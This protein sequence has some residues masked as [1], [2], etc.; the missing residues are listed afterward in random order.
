MGRERRRCRREGIYGYLGLIHP[1]GPQK[2]TASQGNA[3]QFRRSV[4]AD[5]LRPHGPQYARPPCPSP[6]PRVHPDLCPW[7][8]WRH[9]TISSSVVPFSSRL[10]SFP[11]SG[12]FPR[13]LLHSNKTQ[14]KQKFYAEMELIAGLILRIKIKRSDQE[15][16]KYI[17]FEILRPDVP[18]PS[19]GQQRAIS[20]PVFV[21]F[22]VFFF[23]RKLVSLWFL[24][25]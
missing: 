9:P 13:S 18:E 24:S 12:S 16:K 3:V 6:A 2:L 15:R 22:F 19:L 5:S 11:A 25:L 23:L 7:S 20:F 14:K 4:V 17:L 1:I 8:R 10:Q 21:V